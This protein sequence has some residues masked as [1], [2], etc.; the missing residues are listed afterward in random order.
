MNDEFVENL[1]ELN[2]KIAF[3]ESSE[4]VGV[5]MTRAAHNVAPQLEDLRSHAVRHVRQYLNR[6]IQMLRKS[7]KGTRSVQRERFQR[8]HEFPKFLRAH[9]PS[10]AA[11]IE[12]NYIN[13][14]RASVYGQNQTVSSSSHE[15]YRRDGNK[16]RY[17]CGG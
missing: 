3:V 17:D 15:T 9:A 11:E 1:K 13:V 5:G 8:Y 14:L 10:T 16:E 4:D 12:D 7:K 6:S 2:R